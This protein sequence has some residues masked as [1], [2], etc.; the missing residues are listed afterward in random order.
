MGGVTGGVRFPVL[1]R[2]G[3]GT[4]LRHRPPVRGSD[5]LGCTF[6]FTASCS[7]RAAS[8]TNLELRHNKPAVP[9]L[10]A[11]VWTAGE[12][13]ASK[14][15]LR[16]SAVRKKFRLGCKLL[17]KRHDKN[18]H[19]WNKSGISKLSVTTSRCVCGGRPSCTLACG[20]H[21]SD[22]LGAIKSQQPNTETTHPWLFENPGW[23]PQ[24]VYFASFITFVLPVDVTEG[25]VGGLLLLL[26]FQKTRVCV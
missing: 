2:G 8:V 9:V 6:F 21:C 1:W 15:N 18:R 24:G 7:R 19:R 16:V 17:G 4:L 10:S 25:N 22:D 11:T 20:P 5:S 23:N 12:T 13:I 3:V 14:S 26:L